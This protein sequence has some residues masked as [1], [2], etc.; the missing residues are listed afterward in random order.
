MSEASEYPRRPK[1]FAHRF[2]RLLGKVCLGAEIGPDACWLLAFIAHTEDAAGFARPVS[3]FNED[4]ATRLGMSVSAMRRAR[5]RAVKAGWL[6][7]IDGAKRRAPRYFV[8]VPEWASGKDDAP[9]DE[10]DGEL[11]V[12]D[13]G[14]IPRQIDAAT[15][16]EPTDN[17]QATDRE[18]AENRQASGQ[19]SSLVL[20][21]SLSLVQEPP[22]P[23]AEPGKGPTPDELAAEWNRHPGLVPIAG[24]DVNRERDIRSRVFEPLWV[25]HWRA[26]IAFAATMPDGPNGWRPDLTWFLKPG[27]FTQTV[28]KMLAAARSP[29]AAAPKTKREA[30]MDAVFAEYAARQEAAKRKAG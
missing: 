20:P 17:R 12:A 8:T 18:A 11:V 15:D 24:S 4:L 26:A 22:A 6:T 27:K 2:T 21:L 9:G 30:E 19:P 1:F 5:E 7:H 13:G 3:F 29:P 23:A 14:V 25:E 10:H 28:E 16:R